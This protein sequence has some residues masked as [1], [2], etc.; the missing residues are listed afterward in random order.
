VRTLIRD[1]KSHQ[2][3]SAIQMGQKDGMRT[4]N[5]SLAELVKQN[6]ITM[7]AAV[8]RS[9]DVPELERLVGAATAKK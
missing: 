9:M 4:L 5:M 1:S 8:S 3:Y 2:I 6:K 7:E